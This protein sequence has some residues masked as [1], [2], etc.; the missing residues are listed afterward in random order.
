MWAVM[1]V[2]DGGQVVVV[3]MG[4]AGVRAGL[5][6]VVVVVVV[7]AGVRSPWCE[8]VPGGVAGQSVCRSPLTSQPAI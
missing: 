8:L 4:G 7:E 1:Q 2:V 3:V 5:V 6:V